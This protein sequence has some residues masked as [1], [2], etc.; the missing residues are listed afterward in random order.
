MGMT[1]GHM[2]KFVKRYGDLHEEMVAAL[3]RYRDEVRGRSFPGPEHGYGVDAAELEEFRR[4]LE[5]ESLAANGD[6]DWEP[7]A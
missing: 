2:A 3:G 4:Y 6:W 1:T 5:Q 7:L